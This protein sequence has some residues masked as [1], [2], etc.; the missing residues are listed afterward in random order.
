MKFL[1][2]HDYGKVADRLIDVIVIHDMEAPEKG[3]TAESIATYFHNGPATP[4]SAHYCIDD[5]TVV[6]C[7]HDHD[8]AFAAPGANTHGLHFEHAGYARQ[9]KHEWADDYS[10]RM[11]RDVSA[12]LVAQRAAKYGIPVRWLTVADLKA[13]KSGI[14]SHANVSAAFHEST[15]TDPGA[16]FPAAQYIAWVRAAAPAPPPKPSPSP[17]PKPPVVKPTPTPTPV[18]P[19]GDLL[20][21]DLNDKITLPGHYLSNTSNKDQ[22]ITVGALLRHLHEWGYIAV[23]GQTKAKP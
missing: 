19:I 8:V 22:Q 12:P 13:G 16:N 6:Q 21:M 5:N 20:Q 18:P 1:Q 7:V 23:Y 14:T 4:S 9:S 2:A 17:A 15:H 10:T 3:T 11:L